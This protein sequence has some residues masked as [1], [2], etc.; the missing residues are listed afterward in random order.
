M[1]EHCNLATR[2]QRHGMFTSA[3]IADTI[4]EISLMTDSEKADVLVELLRKLQCAN[5]SKGGGE[6][7]PA[8]V[9][10]NRTNDGSRSG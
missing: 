1:G 2:F 9:P 4:A 7:R 5:Q 8:M 10:L 6:G 3:E